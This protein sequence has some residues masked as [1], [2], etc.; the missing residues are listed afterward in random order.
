MAINLNQEIMT[1]RVGSYALAPFNP[2]VQARLDS[3]LVGS[4]LVPSIVKLID[5][6]GGVPVVTPCAVTDVPY[7]V[8]VY[9]GGLGESYKAN[10]MVS[11][12]TDND[13]VYFQTTASAITAGSAVEFDATG[14]VLAS[15]GTNAVLGIALDS[16]GATGGVIRVRI[17]APKALQA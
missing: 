2:A 15:A 5:N 7:G 1:A 16:V 17:T 8:I 11:L 6:V 9:N 4:I 14:K 12:A 3:A 13:V 10:D